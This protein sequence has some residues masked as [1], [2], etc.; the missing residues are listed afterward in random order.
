[1]PKY[2][3]NFWMDGRWRCCAQLEKLA[4]GC[5]H[6][7]PTK[8][9]KTPRMLLSFC[10][11]NDLSTRKQKLSA[12][13][14]Q[15]CQRLNVK[16]YIFRIFKGKSSASTTGLLGFFFFFCLKTY[17]F[18]PSCYSKRGPGT[19]G[20]NIIWEPVRNAN[21]LTPFQVYQIRIRILTRSPEDLC[22][23]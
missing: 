12:S 13:R 2:H 7:D 15:G 6:Y 18:M 19:S 5:A 23:W 10:Q 3:P 20:M 22:A 11:T 8:N 14:H 1:M 9:G 4:V 21:S 17:V 16:F